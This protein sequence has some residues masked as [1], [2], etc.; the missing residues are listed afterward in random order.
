MEKPPARALRMIRSINEGT[1]REELKRISEEE[2]EVERMTYY[3]AFAK[4]IGILRG[5]LEGEEGYNERRDAA[6]EALKEAEEI[7]R[8]LDEY[9]KIRNDLEQADIR[10]DLKAHPEKYFD[11]I[12]AE[13]EKMDDDQ[14][15]KA[16]VTFARAH[17]FKLSKRSA[18]MIK[19]E[20]K[21]EMALNHL[22]L[23]MLFG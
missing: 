15:L 2:D 1:L 14:L 16:S 13:L 21:R 20:K 11:R 17:M 9:R 12:E 3:L 18:E 6:I 8:G 22:K 4:F 5:D 10:I 19:D 23:R 7:S